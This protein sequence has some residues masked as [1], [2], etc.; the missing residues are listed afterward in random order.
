MPF[1]GDFCVLCFGKTFSHPFEV[2]NIKIKLLMIQ[3]DDYGTCFLLPLLSPSVN[4]INLTQF[5]IYFAFA[6]S[7]LILRAL[8]YILICLLYLQVSY[9]CYWLISFV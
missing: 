9:L 7:E 1:P 4:A 5:D 8:K 2:E 6:G 3:S